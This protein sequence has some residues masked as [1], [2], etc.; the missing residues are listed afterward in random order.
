MLIIPKKI[1]DDI[2][3]HSKDSYPEEC[4][5]IL[6]GSDRDGDR[7]IT[8]SHRAKNVAEERRHERYLIDERKLIDVMKTVRGS[9]VDVIGFYHSHPDYPSRPS[10]FDT[11]TAAWPGYSYL[12]ASVEKDGV[13][14]ARS[15]VMP[16]DEG[17][18]VEEPMKIEEEA[19][20]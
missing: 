17:E 19:Q 9:G 6:V 13:A 11:E 4:C 10:G 2:S 18:F 15:W 16:D 14:S 1:F 20:A 8:E 3:E 5:G 12:I 7:I